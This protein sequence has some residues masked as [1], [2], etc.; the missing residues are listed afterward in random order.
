[1]K[2]I[3]GYRARNQKIIDYKSILSRFNSELHLQNKKVKAS[4]SGNVRQNPDWS[5]TE[6]SL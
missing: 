6:L 5:S 2:V 3:S 1:M 4:K